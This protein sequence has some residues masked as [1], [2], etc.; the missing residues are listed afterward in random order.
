[1]ALRSLGLL[2]V[3]RADYK[4]IEEIKYPAFDGSVGSI[5]YEKVM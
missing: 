3:V 2:P 5:V 1:M 4:L